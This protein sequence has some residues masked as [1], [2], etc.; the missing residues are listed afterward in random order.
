MIPVERKNWATPADK[1]AIVVFQAKVRHR[2]GRASLGIFAS[3]NGVTEAARM[4]MLRHDQ[5]LVLVIN[6]AQARD[7]VAKGTI[8]GVL[9]Q[10]W[11]AALRWGAI[12]IL[13]RW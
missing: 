7:A 3:W 12:P 4:E 10:A 1:D 5:P 9:E 8:S 6:G 2:R 13:H 11:L